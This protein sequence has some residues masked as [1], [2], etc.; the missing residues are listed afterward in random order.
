CVLSWTAFCL[1]LCFAQLK[2]S[3]CVLL[4]TNSA[5]LKTALRFVFKKIAFCL[6]EDL[7]FCL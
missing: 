4:R 6:Q 2:T 1:G 3:Y 5:K 7:A